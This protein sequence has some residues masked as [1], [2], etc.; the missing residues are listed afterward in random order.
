MSRFWM[1]RAGRGGYLIDEFQ[2]R[3]C[4]AVGW[5]DVGRVE[6]STT[7]DQL[8]SRVRAAHPEAH[9]SAVANIAAMI[10]KFAREMEPGDKVV[11]Y[12][13]PNREYLLGEVAGEYAFAPDVIPEHDQQRPIRWS[14]RVSRDLLSA[15][16]KNSLGSTLTLFQPGDDVLRQLEAALN[17]VS[18]DE[19]AATD[20][21]DEAAVLKEDQLEKSHEFIKD[22]IL[23]LSAE[24]ME[25]LVAALLRAMGYKARVTP[26][27]PDRGRDVIASPDG[28]G[29][30]T[31]RI[32]AEVKHRRNE[33]I[34]SQIVR[35]FLGA[36]RPAEMGLFVSTGGFTLESQ[37]EAERASVP[38]TLVDLD[39]LALQ[40]VAHYEQFDAEGK[41]L[42]PLTRVYWPAS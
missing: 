40:V 6:P 38:I 7:V 41:A 36:L 39:E 9:P 26:A 23:R 16:A 11:T 8:K 37:Y 29:L 3:G 17:G 18:P 10:W 32:V 42:L 25:R 24:D 4:V 12:D 20:E 33:K 15:E 5:A 31:P 21:D 30:T 34:G 35:G 28:L 2:N 13:A 14:G 22:R 1:V 27:G 19:I